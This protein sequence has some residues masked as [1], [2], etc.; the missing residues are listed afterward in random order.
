M[1]ARA[2]TPDPPRAD[3]DEADADHEAIPA[4]CSRRRRPPARPRT[5]STS[6]VS[7]V[8]AGERAAGEHAVRRARAAL[9][10]ARPARRRTAGAS[11]S[12]ATT[13]Y[14][15]MLFAERVGIAEYLWLCSRRAVH[16][17]RRRLA[18]RRGAL[19]PAAVRRRGVRRRGPRG[20]PGSSTDDDVERILRA[21][22]QVEPFLDEC[23]GPS[24]GTTTRSSA[25]PP[26][27]SRTSRRSRSPPASRGRTR[28]VTIAFGG[29]NWEE[30][31][32]VALQRQFP[33]VDLVFSGEA[34]ESFPAVLAA[35]AAR[36][37]GR[38]DPGVTRAGARRRARPAPRDQVRSSTT[39]R[40]PTSTRTS[41]SAPTA[42]SRGVVA[43][44]A[45]RD[46]ARL[47]VGR[48]LALHVLRA[49]RRD[50]GVP[51][52]E[53]GAGRRGDR[54]PARPVRRRIVQRRRRHPRHALLQT[55]AADARGGRPRRRALLGG[56][57][58]PHRRAGPPAPRRGRRA[59]SSPGSRA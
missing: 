11:T 53:P 31:M 8:R 39:C 50:D 51:Q 47:L 59:T 28:D 20:R 6:D 34:D 22:A 32:G 35:R 15:N 4:R 30:A 2:P 43:D 45:R 3:R 17:V 36:R 25:S 16:G 18:V 10:R 41:S 42:R 52:Q 7:R 23:L 27:S 21:R 14:L 48:A 19:R 12:R 44:P 5:R 40:C 57:G 38:R 9:A 24:P 49:E 13:R 33:F 54:V 37:D 29:A 58:E 1:I 46:G 56:K 55:R 26:S